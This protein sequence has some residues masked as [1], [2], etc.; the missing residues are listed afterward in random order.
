MMSKICATFLLLASWPLACFGEN[1][2]ASLPSRC[3]EEDESGPLRLLIGPGLTFLK[4]DYVDFKEVRDSDSHIFVDNDSQYRSQLMTGAGVKLFDWSRARI[5]LVLAVEI[6]EGGQPVLDGGFLGGGIS[7]KRI[8][9]IVFVGG[10]SRSLGKEL[11]HGFRRSMGQVIKKNKTDPPFQDIDLVDGV[12]AD[13]KD[14]DGLPLF[15]D[16]TINMDGTTK[17]E[18]IFPGNP[19]TNSFNTKLSFGV[20][21]SASIWDKIKKRLKD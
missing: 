6:R 12:I 13:N 4:D 20:L 16:R 5:D 7:F 9:H 2:K 10:L 14:Y 1:L 19:I 8:P 21:I 11:T 3:C 17:K 18:R 15:R